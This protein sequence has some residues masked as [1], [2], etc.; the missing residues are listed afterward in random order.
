MCHVCFM[1]CTHQRGGR[2]PVCRHCHRRINHGARRLLL[3]LWR[4]GGHSLLHNLLLFLSLTLRTFWNFLEDRN[5][6]GAS[7]QS[8]TGDSCWSGQWHGQASTRA[9]WQCASTFPG[10]TGTALSTNCSLLFWQFVRK[11]LTVVCQ[12]GWVANR[13]YIASHFASDWRITMLALFRVRIETSANWPTPVKWLATGQP[14]SGHPLLYYMSPL[15]FGLSF[16]ACQ[17]S[18]WHCL[19]A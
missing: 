15:A 7:A 17:S 3:T 19:C 2:A 9:N 5:V 1:V 8:N 14:T 6:A 4:S 12:S 13:W 16:R 18:W 11:D 10:N